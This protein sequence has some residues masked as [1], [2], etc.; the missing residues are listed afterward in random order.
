MFS[1][2]ETAILL[3]VSAFQVY[4]IKKL[5]SSDDYKL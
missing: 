5:V 2:L 1:V 3:G 4:Y